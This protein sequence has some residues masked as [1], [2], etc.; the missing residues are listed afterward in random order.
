MNPQPL[1]LLSATAALLTGALAAQQPVDPPPW[2]GVQD[3]QT[4]SLYWDFSPP[5]ALVPQQVAVASWYNPAVTVMAPGPTLQLIPALAGHVDVIGLVGNGA[6]QM[7]TMSLTVDNDPH[8]NWVKIFWFQFDTFE[9]NV[10]SIIDSLTQ[11]LAQFER[12]SITYESN[13]IGNGWSTVTITAELWPQPDDEEMD[14]TFL[15]DQ[16]DDVAID[17][18]YVSSR[19]VKV[20]EADEDGRALGEVDGSAFGPGVS[21]L[22]LTTLTGRDCPAA[23]STEDP[24]TFARSYWVS[25]TGQGA[26]PHA[27]FQFTATGTPVGATNLP[28]TVT[29]APNGASDLA[30]ETIPATALT[31]HQ[32]FV[33]ALVD[34]RAASGQVVLYAIDAQTGQLLPGQNVTIPAAVIPGPPQRFGLAF[35]PDGDTGNGSFVVTDQLG[36]GYEV[37]RGGALLRAPFAVPLRAT[38]AGYD[39]TFGRYYFFNARPESTPKG[40]LQVNGHEYSAYD[41]D[42][43]GVRFWGNLQIPNP[44]GSL[45][46]VA[47]GFEAYRRLAPGSRGE[48]RLMCVVDTVAQGS[49]LYELH[50][51]FKYGQSIHG[52]TGMRGQPFELSANFELLLNGLRPQ[53]ATFASLYAGFSNTQG[54]GTALPVNLAMFGLD[55]SQLLMSGEMHSQLLGPQPNGQFRFTM[56][57]LPPGFGGAPL[58]FQWLVFDP[59]AQN[60][61]A[62]SSA[63]KTLI[64]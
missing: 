6:P 14:W 8:L 17:N 24:A 7:E 22:Q 2:W 12:S 11:D 42:A 51:P 61:L 25:A 56:P 44:G 45:G 13:P 50:A 53:T 21:I 37:D 10:G 28:A 40:P 63:A 3:E 55:E 62:M 60:G 43:T 16:F 20:D 57:P 33:Y 58:F 1:S 9:G 19:C 35:N 41:L 59:T 30:V 34:L 54:F 27:V 23:A 5:N 47:Q 39:P 49:L 38:G 29:T 26:V 31:P 15:T 18:L 48:L 32:Q 46:G 64:Y 36:N 52:V 4:L